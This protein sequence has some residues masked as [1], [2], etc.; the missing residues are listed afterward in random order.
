MRAIAADRNRASLTGGCF[1]PRIIRICTEFCGAEG[2]PGR[3]GATGPGNVRLRTAFRD[4]RDQGSQAMA[5]GS[6]RAG[7]HR[8]ARWPGGLIQS[9]PMMGTQRNASASSVDPFYTAQSQNRVVTHL[10]S[11]S[12][13]RARNSQRSI[14]ASH[15]SFESLAHNSQRGGAALLIRTS[16]EIEQPHRVIPG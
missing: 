12:T 11:R 9:Q 13:W 7:L 3:L 10:S 1:E 4:R 2:E 6:S 14:N 5:R 15:C 16:V 8:P